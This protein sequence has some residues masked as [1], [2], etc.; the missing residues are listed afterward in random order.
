[1]RN[2][3]NEN[4]GPNFNSSYFEKRK[5]LRRKAKLSSPIWSSPS[6]SEDE[7]PEDLFK[8]FFKTNYYFTE[9]PIIM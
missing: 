7:T 1:M 2:Y 3:K 8:S 5:E 9:E 6:T 4:Y